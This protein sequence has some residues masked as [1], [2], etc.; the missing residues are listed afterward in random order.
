MRYVK[1]VLWMALAGLTLVIPFS[2]LAEDQRGTPKPQRVEAPPKKPPTAAAMPVY[3]PP[4]RGAPGGRVGGG[5][6]GG[7]KSPM[8]YVLALA[9]D[10]TGL[11]VQEQPAL[12]WYLSGETTYP[13]EVTIIKNQAIEP[14]FVTRLTPPFNPACTAFG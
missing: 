3:K 14:L 13:V 6:R 8:L 7:D 12:F 1:Q 9:P 11:T 10:H 5:T 4:V 2:T